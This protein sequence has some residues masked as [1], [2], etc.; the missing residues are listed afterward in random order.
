MT[1]P[2]PKTQQ[3]FALAMQAHQAGRLPQAEQLCRQVLAEYPGHADALHMLGVIAAQK[4]L[5]G[6]AVDL[7]RQAIALIPT[8]PGAH[9]NLAKALTGNNQ[10][11]EAIAAYRQ[12][13]ALK[14]GYAEAHHNLSLLLLLLGDMAQGWKE[15]EWRSLCNNMA[16][17]RRNIVQ[18]QW[19]GSPLANR[20][21]LLHPEQGFGDTIQFIRYAPLVAQRGGRVLVGCAPEL[22]RLLQNMPGV[23]RCLDSGL[24]LPPFDVHCPLLSLPLAFGTTLETIPHGVPYLQADAAGV[25]HWRNKLALDPAGF[26]VG[27]VWAGRPTHKNER[28]RSLPLAALAPLA[29]VPGVRFYS[30]QKGEAAQQART[31]PQGLALIDHTAD[32]HDFADTA[33]L[34]ANLDLVI[35]VDTAVVHLAGALGKPVWTLLPFLP[36]WRWLLNR[37]D[38]P[39]YPSMRLFR[40]GAPGD[41]S[42]VIQQVTQ[43]LANL[44]R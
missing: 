4:G 17:P 25:E 32:L 9:Y 22:R 35:A 5:N 23:G 42:G 34:I 6:A 28:N 13:I 38:T 19:D 3:A 1:M 2:S 36:D 41:W 20:T 37:T 40:Q 29:Q 14:P 16:V 18:R 39:W 8:S 43:A 27:L 44:P 7:I 30:L 21:I 31:P 26:K 15:Y 33:A 24:M 11:T 10:L 12:T